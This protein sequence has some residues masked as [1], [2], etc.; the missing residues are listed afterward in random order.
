LL[1][2]LCA[3]RVGSLRW[4]NA[5]FADL[6]REL[7]AAGNAVVDLYLPA[8]ALT[9]DREVVSLDADFARI[10]GLRRMPV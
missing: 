4:C 7:G 6:C 10:P 3:S 2:S 1:E 8:L 9:H 5:R